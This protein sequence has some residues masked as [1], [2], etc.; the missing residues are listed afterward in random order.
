M[1]EVHNKIMKTSTLIARICEDYTDSATCT[2]KYCP[3]F[4]EITFGWTEG[5]IISYRILKSFYD[6]HLKS[7]FEDNYKKSLFFKL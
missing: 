5:E 3:N 7:I 1:P 6:E 2:I 4:T